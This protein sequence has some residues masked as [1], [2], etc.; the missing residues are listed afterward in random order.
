MLFSTAAARAEDYVLTLKDHKFSPQE[1]V[2]P[3]DQK[4]KITVKNQD[5]TPAEFESSDLSREKVVSANSDIIVLV[6]PL[7]AGSYKYFDDMHR[8]TTTGVITVK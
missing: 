4:V 3:A 6:G 7:K 1:L 2:I 5:P 8:N